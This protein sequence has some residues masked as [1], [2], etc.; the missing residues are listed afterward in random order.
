MTSAVMFFLAAAI[1]K[2]PQTETETNGMEVTETETIADEFSSQSNGIHVIN[3]E[4]CVE[5]NGRTLYSTDL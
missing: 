4:K 1:Y 5:T 3:P 2:P